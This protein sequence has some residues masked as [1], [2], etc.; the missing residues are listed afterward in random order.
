[1]SG[2]ISE[3]P[4]PTTNSGPAGIAAGPDGNLWFAE[5]NSNQIGRITVSGAISEFPVPTASSGPAGIAAGPDGN[6]WFAELN[7]N[8]I[9]RVMTTPQAPPKSVFLPICS[10][11]HLTSR[12]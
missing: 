4:V 8:Q 3:F 6:L 10:R 1:V 12:N 2:A 11:L 7:S 9:G 5:L